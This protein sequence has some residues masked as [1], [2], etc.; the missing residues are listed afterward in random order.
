MDCVG[1]PSRQCQPFVVQDPC[2]AAA[3][4]HASHLY[5]VFSHFVHVPTSD[6][7]MQFSYLCEIGV[8][9]GGTRN[10]MQK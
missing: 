2:F 10:A 6:Y 8:A 1:I 5:P 7:N 9:H 3:S 4:R